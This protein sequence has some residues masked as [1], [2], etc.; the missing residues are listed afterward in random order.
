MPAK[1]PDA[2]LNF[3]GVRLDD[4]TKAAVET[5]AAADGRTVSGWILAVVKK[6]LMGEALT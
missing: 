5:A 2:K 4:A 6:A 3:I 1:K